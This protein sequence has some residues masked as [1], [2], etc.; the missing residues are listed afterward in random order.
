MPKSNWN[1]LD[2]E[3]QRLIT[4]AANRLIGLYMVKDIVETFEKIN[5]PFLFNQ[6][7]FYNQFCPDTEAYREDIEDYCWEKQ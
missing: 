3:E 1:H 4:D 6:P 2:P 5:L 7:G